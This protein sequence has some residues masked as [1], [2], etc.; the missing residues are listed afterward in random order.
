M[1][2]QTY[3]YGIDQIGSVR[4]AFVD[5]STA[6]VYDYDPYGVM[7]SAAA[8]VADFGYAG[9]FGGTDSGLYLTQFRAYDPSVGRWISRDPQWNRNEPPSISES[10]VDERIAAGST[11]RGNSAVGPDPL[12]VEERNLYEYV[13]DSPAILVDPLG[14]ASQSLPMIGPPGIVANPNGHQWRVYNS[15]GLAIC[16]IERHEHMTYLHFHFYAIPGVGSS[17]GPGVSMIP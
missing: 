8:P 11:I 9:M 14:L 6:P 5:A 7:T 1:A 10:S 12:A 15:N 16:D 13:Y 17:R 2:P 3:F 4:R